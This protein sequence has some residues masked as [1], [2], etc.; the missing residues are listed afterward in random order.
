MGKLGNDLCSACNWR[1]CIIY[2]ICLTRAVIRGTACDAL[3]TGKEQDADYVHLI[4]HSPTPLKG[5]RGAGV[6]ILGSLAE[7]K[8]LGGF[9]DTLRPR[10][11][12][13]RGL[14]PVSLDLFP[15]IIPSLT[16][17]SDIWPK[18]LHRLNENI[19]LFLVVPPYLYC[20]SCGLMLSLLDTMTGCYS[21][22][23]VSNTGRGSR[24]GSHPT[25]HP[26]FR[27]GR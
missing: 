21:A 7:W 8:N 12:I 27:A 10:S 1:K 26:P 4:A 13:N 18:M 24:R 14:S 5:L 15:S 23:L 9:S 6:S 2:S 20:A 25:V 11:A 3:F 19:Q 17:L 22:D 16:S